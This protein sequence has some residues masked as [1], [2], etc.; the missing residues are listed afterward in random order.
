MATIGPEG[1]KVMIDQLLRPR[2]ISTNSSWNNWAELRRR[3][4]FF[5][6]IHQKPPF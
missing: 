2:K 3:F 6:D 1:R 5:S 4:E